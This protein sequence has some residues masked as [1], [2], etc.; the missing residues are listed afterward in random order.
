MKA[1]REKT[2]Q[3]SMPR[4]KS[5]RT[6]LA[7]RSGANTL[8]QNLW[9][10]SFLQPQNYRGAESILP[11]FELVVPGRAGAEPLAQL[12]WGAEKVEH[13]E[14]TGRFI[15]ALSLTPSR[16]FFCCTVPLLWFRLPLT[17]WAKCS[18]GCQGSPLCAV[19]VWQ[20]GV[21]KEQLLFCWHEEKSRFGIKMIHPPAPSSDQETLYN[22]VWAKPKAPLQWNNPCE[23]ILDKLWL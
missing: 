2:S 4:T 14:Q 17:F 11:G 19:P 10:H 13:T 18:S 20:R 15:S 7:A 23:T 9:F 8:P 1:Q 22:T 6:I 21:L 5:I 12:S 3:L 16:V